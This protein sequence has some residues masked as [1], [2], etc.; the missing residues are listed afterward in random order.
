MIELSL[1]G[2]FL[3]ITVDML[4][5]G[6]KNFEH[7]ETFAQLD[8]PRLILPEGINSR[9][10]I[11]EYCKTWGEPIRRHEDFFT[12]SGF[13]SVA[14]QTPITRS[15]SD[16]SAL[17]QGGAPPLLKGI[18]DPLSSSDSTFTQAFAT[19]QTNI[20]T[21]PLAAWE[22]TLGTG[23]LPLRERDS[24]PPT[25]INPA[26][27]DLRLDS[28]V[29]RSLYSWSQMLADAG[30]SLVSIPGHSHGFEIEN[31]EEQ[32]KYDTFEKWFDEEVENGQEQE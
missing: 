14:D 32:A 13:P 23:V 27:L 2:R 12:N 20:A 30:P 29:D 16:G 8:H 26:V 22:Q 24:G 21:P 3:F 11:I 7:L 6:Q 5:D 25:T 9:E 28:G 18:P 15:P 1:H 31:D 17:Q 4:V 10:E 19:M